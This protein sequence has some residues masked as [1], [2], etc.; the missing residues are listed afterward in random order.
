MDH[1]VW[2]SWLQL[3]LEKL[4]RTVNFQLRH[5]VYKLQAEFFAKKKQ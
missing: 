2:T 3:A 4:L 5:I 1:V